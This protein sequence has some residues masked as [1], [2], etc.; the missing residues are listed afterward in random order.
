MDL[1]RTVTTAFV[2]AALCIAAVPAAAQDRNDS[3]RRGE[4]RAS[5]PAPRQERAQRAA[6]RAEAPRQDRAQRAEAPRA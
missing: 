4:R 1:K 2:A 3:Q 5:A 6:P